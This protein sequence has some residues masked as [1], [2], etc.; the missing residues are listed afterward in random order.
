MVTKKSH[1][2]TCENL[3]ICRISKT[4]L[5]VNTFLYSEFPSWWRI[6]RAFY[7]NLKSQPYI[8]FENVIRLLLSTRFITTKCITH[9]A[10]LL[11][12]NYPGGQNFV[13]TSKCRSKFLVK[14]MIDYHTQ[15]TPLFFILCQMCD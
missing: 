8:Y 11:R 3:E 12:V 6:L 4:G 7:H 1:Q 9:L 14:L 2:L 15:H 5:K 10:V 13:W